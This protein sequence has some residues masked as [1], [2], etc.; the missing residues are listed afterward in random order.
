MQLSRTGQVVARVS[1]RVP[2]DTRGATLLIELPLGLYLP[3]EVRL[4]IDDGRPSELPFQ[5]CQTQGSLASAP[6]DAD[7]LGALRTGKQFTLATQT[8]N[9][10]PLTFSIPLAEFGTNFER[11]Q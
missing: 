8:S 5:T 11:V 6:V 9:R 10:E 1:V 2:G 3:A 7:M 4:Q